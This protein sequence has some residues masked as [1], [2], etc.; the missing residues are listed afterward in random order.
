MFRLVRPLALIAV[1]LGTLAAFAG[2][3]WMSIEYP[4]NPHDSTTRGAFLVVNTYHHGDPAEMALQGS[5]EG[6]VRGERRTVPLR[7]AATARRGS[8]AVTRQWPTEGKWVLSI[9]LREGNSTGA[10]ALVVLGED[11]TPSNVT[12]PTR[13]DGPWQVPRAHTSA[14]IQSALAGAGEQRQ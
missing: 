9:L 13:R 3:P 5:A 10:S 1:T 14:E 7:F 4:A 2:P 8:Y 6:I 12:V 11:G